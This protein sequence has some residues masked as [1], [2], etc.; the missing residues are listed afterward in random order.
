ML[1]RMFIG[2]IVPLC[3]GLQLAQM[4]GRAADPANTPEIEQDQA[5]ILELQRN[6]FPV[7]NYH[8][9]LKEN[10]GQVR[11]CHELRSWFFG[12]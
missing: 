7:I 9:H 8:V 6:G 5:R 4:V 3:A 2:T 1:N 11:D 10:G 12:Y